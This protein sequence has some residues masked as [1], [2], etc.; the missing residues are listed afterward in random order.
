MVRTKK[1]KSSLLL[2]KIYDQDAQGKSCYTIAKG[3]T[4]E[5]FKISHM[6]VKR[7]LDDHK[8]H[9]SELVNQDKQ[10]VDS[11]KSDMID[12]K[13]QIS[14]I[15]NSLLKLMDGDDVERSFKLAVI[16]QATATLKLVHEIMTEFKGIHIKQGP[17][18][19][20]E[21]V[22]VIVGELNELEKTGQIKIINPELKKDGVKTNVGSRSESESED[23]KQ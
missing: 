3:L 4:E 19:K 2:S 16:K 20:I 21:L 18:S 5:G 12:I 17:Q 23:T 15:Y 1:I 8:E 22:Q 11:M 7:Y 9:K 13:F 6:T 14:S 10:M